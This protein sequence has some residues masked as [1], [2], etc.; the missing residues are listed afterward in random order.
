M[1][2]LTPLKFAP[3]LKS[4]IWGGREICRYKGLEDSLTPIGESWEISAIEGHESQVSEGEFAGRTLTEMIETYGEALLGTEVY[5]RYKG[6]FPLLIKLIDADA[7]LSVQVHPDDELAKRRHG[8]LGKTEMWYIIRS[9][10]GAKIY[11]GF[12]HRLTEEECV[13]HI[14]DKTFQSVL[15]IYNSKPGDVYFIP[16]GRVHAIGAGNMLLE[17]QE[18]SDITYRIY[19]YDRRDAEGK[20]R[21]LHIE[22]A[23]EAID[24]EQYDKSKEESC[25]DMREE[26]ELVKCD[27]FTTYRIN[28]SGEYELHNDGTSFIVLIC[29]EGDAAIKYD[30]GQEH[31]SQGNTIMIPASLQNV[32]IE[33]KATII[34]TRS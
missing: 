31:L 26:C 11:S 6:K 8:S 34:A 2:E 17:I 25:D 15:S 10:E 28:L 33:G 29:I 24:Y 21:E 32:T 9:K 16:A 30:G 18:S 19:D 20:P 27:Y 22:L 14:Q 1:I 12:S 4:V 13:N 5:R 23:K 7:D 3:Y